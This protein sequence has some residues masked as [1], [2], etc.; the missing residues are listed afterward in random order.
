MSRDYQAALER[1]DSKVVDAH[2]AITKNG[3]LSRSRWQVYDAL[4]LFGPLSRNELDVRLKGPDMPNPTFSR[5]LVELERLGVAV[6]G[7]KRPCSV[8]GEPCDA[9][10]VTSNLPYTKRVLRRP[11]ARDI[12]GDLARSGPFF[13]TDGDCIFC[14][15]G[16]H[17]RAPDQHL[18]KCIWRRAKAVT[19]L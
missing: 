2:E 10:D 3:L 15:V 16:P 4:F 14:E 11:R 12:V 5:R 17:I 7:G 18:V 8:T 19:D 13:D 6:R 9:W 1:R